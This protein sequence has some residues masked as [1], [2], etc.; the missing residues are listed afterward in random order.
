MNLPSLSYIQQEASRT[1]RRFPFA[2]LTAIFA[3]VCAVW[4]IDLEYSERRQYEFL[5]RMLAV[6]ILGISF[7]IFIVITVE[8]NKKNRLWFWGGQLTGLVILILYYFSLPAEFFDG[9]TKHGIRYALYL[10]GAHLL[11]AIAPFWKKGEINAFWQY[12]KTLFLRILTSVLFSHVLYI[13]LIVAMLSIDELFGVELPDEW[14]GQL[15]VL[16]VG[17]F[18]T[19]FFLA[20]I[21]ENL[22]R[23]ETLREY[24]KGLKII[25]QYILIPLVIIYLLILY[26]YAGKIITEW[27]WPEGWVAI[28]TLSFS[29]VGIFSL[30]L[31]YPIQEK[32]EN[33]W[34]KTFSRY[35]YI[36]LIP[37]VIMLLLA[38]WRRISEYG[39]T[40]NRYFVLI[41][42]F[43]LTG[44]VI[45]F[46]VSKTKSIKVIPGSLC[47]ITFLISFGPW[48]AFSVSEN[49]QINRL[50]SLL[51]ESRILI[52]GEIHR[53]GHDV[54]DHDAQ[55]ISAVVRYLSEVHGLSGIQPWFDEDLENL[56]GASDDS[57]EQTARWDQPRK[58]VEWM[59]VQYFNAR[60]LQPPGLRNFTARTEG[61][62]HIDEYEWLIKNRN[63]NLSQ[64]TSSVHLDQHTLVIEMDSDSLWFTINKMGD[65]SAGELKIELEPKIG[66]LDRTFIPQESYNIPPELM[67]LEGENEWIRVKINLNSLIVQKEEGRWVIQ[68]VLADIFISLKDDETESS[69]N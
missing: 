45:Y 34:I 22:D 48:G 67:S 14:Y 55:E 52:D 58:V 8:K 6:S 50:E 54:P 36:S 24:P 61:A 3:A 57:T 12:N 16:I 64:D 41:L 9:L 19:W 18:N 25:T 66:E 51:T 46:I 42:G 17:V 39:F 1:I 31:L 28:L 30:L 32:V 38:I 65:N 43:W 56:A 29:V 60:E 53:T 27:Q 35:F 7:F 23:L 33:R 69:P 68:N 20:G 5:F 13:G 10:I 47:V 2:L 26:L 11:V 63:F 49:S 59:G 44:I 40:E 21:P 4:L 15:W 37:L 62:L